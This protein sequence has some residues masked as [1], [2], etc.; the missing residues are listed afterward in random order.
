MKYQSTKTFTH[1]SGISACFRQWKAKSH[2]HFLHGYALQVRIEFEAEKLD[3]R[4]WV[5]DFGG[6]KPIKK[7]IEDHF[8]H[9]TIAAS[10]DPKLPLF[11]EMHQAGLMDLVIVEAVGCEKFA[12]L[13]F[14]KAKEF[15]AQSEYDGRVQV[16]RVEVSEHEG[17]SAIVSR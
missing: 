7:W 13:I 1:A 4:N 3:E 6:L 12:E 5:V 14:K 2:C 17:N 9:K 8:D 16:S 10:D 11:V 15:I